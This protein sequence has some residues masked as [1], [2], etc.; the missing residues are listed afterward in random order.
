MATTSSGARRSPWCSATRRRCTRS[1][2]PV[3]ARSV[4]RPGSRR[5]SRAGRA[6]RRRCRRADPCRGRS[7][8]TGPALGLG[9]VQELGDHTDGQRVSEIGNQ[10][11]LAP[12]VDARQE[13]VHDRVDPWPDGADARD[14]R[15]VQERVRRMAVR[16]IGRHG[17][18]R[19]LWRRLES[20]ACG[21]R[22]APAIGREASLGVQRGRDVVVTEQHPRP[23][24]LAPVD[25][26]AARSAAY[27]GYGSASAASVKGSK[28]TTRPCGPGSGDGASP[29]RE[30]AARLCARCTAAGVLR[31]LKIR[32]TKG[33]SAPISS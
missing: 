9:D 29:A 14:H 32:P 7:S 21:T 19:R 1:S 2:P 28:R 17:A 23:Q 31:G 27:C 18:K 11:D 33:V 26:I 12:P 25:G 15:G 13:L 30:P 20:A 10:V 4:T 22:R 16:R 5:R 8:A 3:S 6:R 24:L